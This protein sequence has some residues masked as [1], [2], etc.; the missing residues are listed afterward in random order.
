MSQLYCFFDP[1]FYCIDHTSVI[2][3]AF[4][5]IRTTHCT[6]HP[7]LARGVGRRFLSMLWSLWITGNIRW[8]MYDLEKTWRKNKLTWMY[9]SNETVHHSSQFTTVYTWGKSPKAEEGEKI[10]RLT[11][12]HILYR[13]QNELSQFRRGSRYGYQN[14]F[15]L[16]L[17]YRLSVDNMRPSSIPHISSLWNLFLMQFHLGFCLWIL[18]CLFSS[19]LVPMSC[20]GIHL[21]WNVPPLQKFNERKVKKGSKSESRMT[22]HQDQEYHKDEIDENLENIALFRI[23]H[24]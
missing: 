20:L 23:A 17:N 12:D 21:K 24:R 9:I 1:F 16:K 2:Q 6:K 19:H 5:T 4:F 11:W 8:R 13:S 15:M 18:T 3:I 10:E 7:A 22:E 14:A